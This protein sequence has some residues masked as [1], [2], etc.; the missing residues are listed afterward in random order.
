[1]TTVKARTR[2]RQTQAGRE[3]RL[4]LTI[5]A[6]V[7]SLAALALAA[8][9]FAT[10][11]SGE[12]TLEAN[13]LT[14]TGNAVYLT[15][16]SSHELGKS[17]MLV[18]QDG[19]L[20]QVLDI[21]FNTSFVNSGNTGSLT[22][23]LN[24]LDVATGDYNDTR[25]ALGAAANEPHMGTFTGSIISDNVPAKSGMQELVTALRDAL[26]NPTVPTNLNL[27]TL[28]VTGTT[29]LNNGASISGGDL[30]LNNNNLTNVGAVTSTSLAVSGTATLA[31]ATWT[32]D[33]N[34]G[35]NTITTSADITLTGVLSAVGALNATFDTLTVNTLLDMDNHEIKATG[36][37]T[38]AGLVLDQ[39]TG[40]DYVLTDAAGNGT[41]SWASLASLNL[42]TGSGTATR[43]PYFTGATTLADTDFRYVTG[44]PDT[45]QNLDGS[46][47]FDADAT[48]AVACGP[49]A[50]S[51]NVDVSG[52]VTAANM[53]LTASG[54]GTL[55]AVLTNT[56]SGVAAWQTL[57]S[58]GVVTGTGISGR[59]VVWSGSDT[60]TSSSWSS[61]GNTLSNASGVLSCAS[62]STSGNVTAGGDIN[63]TGDILTTAGDFKISNAITAAT[64][65]ILGDVTS[66]GGNIVA[67]TGN[68]I[69]TNVVASGSVTAN[70]DV[71]ATNGD[72]TTLTGDITA[73]TGSVIAGNAVLAGTTVTAGTG[74]IATTGNITA[75]AGDLIATAGGLFCKTLRI[76]NGATVNYVLTDPAG[77]G[78]GV[79]TAPASIV[80][81][82]TLNRLRKANGSGQLV[83]ANISDNGTT[84]SMLVD[85]TVAGDLT[86]GSGRTLQLG[87]NSGASLQ[88]SHD[89]T[90]GLILNT[91]G[92][93]T[94]ENSDATGELIYKVAPLSAFVI[95]D[96]ASTALFQVNGSGQLR[97]PPDA[98]EGKV[99]TSDS[100]GVASWVFRNCAQTF[101][102]YLVTTAQ[103]SCPRE[104]D[105]LF[106]FTGSRVC[107]TVDYS[108]DFNITAD[109]TL[110]IPAGITVTWD[111][112]G[113]TPDIT[114]GVTLT[115]L[116]QGRLVAG[117]TL[118]YQ[119]SIFADGIEVV[120]PNNAS[121]STF[122]GRAV[123]WSTGANATLS[124]VSILNN[125][126]G[127]NTTT[128]A[129]ENNITWT[130]I[131]AAGWT[132]DAGGT[133]IAVNISDSTLN[134]V[135]TNEAVKT[136]SLTNVV[137]VSNLVLANQAGDTFTADVDNCQI[138][139][140]LI[141][142]G[143]SGGGAYTC[144]ITDCVVDGAGNVTSNN[145]ALTLQNVWF[146]SGVSVD[147]TNDADQVVMIDNCQ[148]TSTTN[149][150]V[151]VST[152][153]F[154]TGCQ[155]T[156]A[157]TLA[158]TS[159][160]NS[161]VSE[162]TFS[163]GM[164]LQLSSTC[165]RVQFTHN[166]VGSNVTWSVVTLQ[167]IVGDGNVIDGT[168]T[169]SNTVTMSG[170]IIS[171]N[172]MQAL[173]ATGVVTGAF[174]S[175][176][177]TGPISGFTATEAPAGFN[178]T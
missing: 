168:W 176:N 28:T 141:V 53:T 128:W 70:T 50:A 16:P 164:A 59:L 122:T 12:L 82:G 24:T 54:S 18:T 3:I 140:S 80:T 144:R 14:N 121:V 102:Y 55:N 38:T 27:T 97:Y 101:D 94:V 146:G 33:L 75:T 148:F 57:G 63:V 42:L 115:L 106:G 134:V 76:T 35:N 29:T 153:V 171:G 37:V 43:I 85:T 19:V 46:V 7:V 136:L 104:I 99:L 39:A 65:T 149:W 40:V 15:N 126:S 123:R 73:T 48:G 139:G 145:T 30:N 41:A 150:D 58:L 147:I 127:G 157:C 113:G 132:L 68:V 108:L 22:Q 62:V 20:D 45:L 155:F 152:R 117:S 98:A 100:T 84:V 178:R 143:V 95:Q 120:L 124:G 162:N 116:G 96:S 131:T 110:Y 2:P 166:V 69:G 56:G 111:N 64:A 8:A 26:D 137:L 1:M 13:P 92:S 67:T 32:G 74:F 129:C 5:S 103:P 107:V 91:A 138:R 49:L 6:F 47:V 34:M 60:V 81:G 118:T 86:L 88:L 169:L 11:P 72:I 4:A 142:I 51:G 165:L 93:L 17:D 112:L 79:W 167:D 31:G 130:G 61:S 170:L 154:I 158:G 71:V 36:T 66:S 174:V 160:S 156:E 83:D 109:T 133:D 77:N 114:A 21:R 163:Q 10:G 177:I 105:T 78:T 23:I 52:R 44:A 89:N 175:A 172:T 151:N 161:H 159:L 173:T 9:V 90:N 25:T 119:G 125:A 135:D 87:T